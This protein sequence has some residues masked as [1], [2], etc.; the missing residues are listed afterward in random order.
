LKNT[1]RRGDFKGGVT[2]GGTRNFSSGLVLILIII[3][4]KLQ[5]IHL[6]LYKR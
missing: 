1:Q 5:A 6:M 3:Y 2:F 4:K